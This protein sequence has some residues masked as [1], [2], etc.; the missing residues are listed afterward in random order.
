[1]P[2]SSTHEGMIHGFVKESIEFHQVTIK[3][4]GRL[5]TFLLYKDFSWK[6]FPLGSN[7]FVLDPH[8]FEDKLWVVI[9]AR[10]SEPLP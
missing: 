5:L 6:V 3:P 2:F 1:M 4:D 7:C 9:F 8:D 10:R